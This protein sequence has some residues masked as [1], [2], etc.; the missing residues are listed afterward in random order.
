MMYK[1]VSRVHKIANNAIFHLA[2]N[3]NQIIKLI[4]LL[5]CVKTDVLNLKLS[6]FHHKINVLTALNYLDL[7]VNNAQIEVII[8]IKKIF[9]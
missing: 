2:F 3:V 4:P 7:I 8:L 1:Y 6:G 5:I 9:F